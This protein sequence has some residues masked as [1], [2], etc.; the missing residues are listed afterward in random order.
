MCPVQ[1]VTYVSGRSSPINT[2]LFSLFPFSGISLKK[3]FCQ[4]FV[5]FTIGGLQY[6]QG[7][8]DPSGEGRTARIGLAM[9]R[10]PPCQ[11]EGRARKCK[12]LQACGRRGKAFLFSFR[13]DSSV[14]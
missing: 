10:M 1:C 8:Q 7:R 3:P 11:V 6:T 14:G 13:G 2:R 4:P 5:N 12:T 9:S